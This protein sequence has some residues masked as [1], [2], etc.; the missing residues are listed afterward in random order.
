MI[1]CIAMAQA[2]IP[3]HGDTITA[4]D[5][6]PPGASLNGN[7]LAVVIT[8]DSAEHIKSVN[9]NG[10]D[11]QANT[12][13]TWTIGFF[14]TIKLGTVKVDDAEDP[15]SDSDIFDIFNGT[16]TIVIAN[17]NGLNVS[18][19]SDGDSDSPAETGEVATVMN[20]PVKATY[21]I[22]SPREVPEPASLVLLGIGLTA[23]GVVY[24]SK[25]A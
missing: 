18:F 20:G 17:M 5:A 21:T 10:K 11:V 8:E 24:G 2:V 25:K 14:G 7:N 12:G 4:A 3:A 22:V 16:A 13:G 23:L 1:V 6:I 9:V 15:T 19:T